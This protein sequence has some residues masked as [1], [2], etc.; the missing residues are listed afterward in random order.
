MAAA[1]SHTRM[2]A[3]IKESGKIIKCMAGGN[4]SIK[5]GR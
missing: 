4:C 5:M 1:N 2:E 3:T